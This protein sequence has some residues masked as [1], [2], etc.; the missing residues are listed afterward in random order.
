MHTQVAKIVSIS[1]LLLAVVFW[2]S[3][4]NY[5]R[6]LNVVVSLAAAVVLVQAYR[7]K[8]YYW[9]AGFVGIA[10]LFNPA[11][12]AFR[13]GGSLGLLLVMLSIVPFAMSL[14]GL[15]PQPRMSIAS[16]TDRT[17]GSKSL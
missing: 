9:G 3:V 5:Q 1:A 15:R 2:T 6:E 12:P 13:L 8:K 7:L 14:L 16:I 10:L 11:V 17:P 4:A